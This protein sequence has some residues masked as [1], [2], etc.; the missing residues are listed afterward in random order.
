MKRS[1]QA[2]KQ[3]IIAG[4]NNNYLT[5][6]F[7]AYYFDNSIDEATYKKLCELIKSI[8]D[9][10]DFENLDTATC[11]RLISEYPLSRFYLRNIAVVYNNQTV[12]H[13][14]LTFTVPKNLSD[15]AYKRE[16]L[17]SIAQSFYAASFESFRL[18]I[19]NYKGKLSNDDDVDF[20]LKELP[21][22]FHYTFAKFQPHLINLDVYIQC[23]EYDIVYIALENLIIEQR[24]DFNSHAIV[25]EY[26][27]DKVSFDRYI[28]LFMKY[29]ELARSSLK[30]CG[31][32]C[33]TD[34]CN[35]STT[36]TEDEIPKPLIRYMET[37]KLEVF[38]CAVEL[39]TEVCE[40]IFNMT[41]QASMPRSIAS[42]VTQEEIE[43]ATFE[44]M[45]EIVK[46]LKSLKEEVSPTTLESIARLNKVKQFLL[47]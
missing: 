32:K 29:W 35:R 43:N 23:N 4:L 37:R 28:P 26:L 33:L 11:E 47:I 38:C 30:S 20:L 10:V 31:L 46:T 15:H 6:F 2:S 42:T 27:E 7:D 45:N 17:E 44:G 14:L 24:L 1:T 5:G 40:I 8:N 3:D 21:L 12:V 39:P 18:L 41:Q 25:K 16:Y 34:I 36:F 9:T 13:Y 19:T 22:E